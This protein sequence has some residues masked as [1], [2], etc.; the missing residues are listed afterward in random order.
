MR[1]A[2]FFGGTNDVQGHVEAAV[3]SEKDGFD[4]I[5]YGQ[6]FGPD[7]LS[8]I[9]LAGQKTTRIEL[10]TSVVPTYPRHPVLMA[11]QAL[12]TQAAA[13]GRFSLGVG[14]SHRPVVEA[15]WGMSYDRPAIHM[16]EYLSVLRPL[17]KEGRV[18]FNGAFFRVNATVQ[19]ATSNPP[20]VL[21]AA[22][23]PVMLRIAGELADGTVTWMVGPKTLETH[24]VPR[25]SSSAEEAGRPT[26]R[27]VVALPI[28]VT[29]DAAEGRQRAA[30]LFQVYGTLP[31]YR[32]VL[33]IE[34]AAGPAE[35]A[36]VGN[37]EEV[38]SQLRRIA[39]AGATDFLAG[40]FP[41]EDDAQAS[42]KRTRT[43][44]KA[45]VGAF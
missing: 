33:D 13:G 34:G 19:V 44:L 29:D 30:R 42:L 26:P 21:T 45:L 35:V 23:A 14:L 17:L 20:P 6:I 25:I 41:A 43:L 16:R 2:V 32:R 3:E 38:E 4:G 1:I 7:V 8:V 27:V 24:I 36:V 5:W 18:S 15:M 22:L 40:A 12:T 11:Q 28:A 10:G 39:A 37:E 31:N 9:A